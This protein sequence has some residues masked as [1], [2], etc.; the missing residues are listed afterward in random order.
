MDAAMGCIRVGGIFSTY[1]NATRNNDP[2]Y[3]Y[4]TTNEAFR[5]TLENDLG[6][7]DHTLNKL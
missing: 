6:P 5:N 3:Y 4:L 7:L 1:A 2:N